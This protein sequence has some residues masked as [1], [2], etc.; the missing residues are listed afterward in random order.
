MAT[1]KEEIQQH[2]RKLISP[3]KEEEELKEVLKTRLT[4]KEFKVLK[5]KVENIPQED[6]MTKLNLDDKQYA[7]LFAKIVKKLN[8][9]K[10]KQEMMT[11]L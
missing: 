3:L 9:E 10:L 4:K 5:G 1:L 7:E 2:I 6:I 11:G 8:Q